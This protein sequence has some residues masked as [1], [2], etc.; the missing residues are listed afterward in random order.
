MAK[1]KVDKEKCIG[2]GLCNEICPET[3]EM[4]GD[5]ATVRKPEVSKVTCEKE[6]EKS[7]PTE[8]ITVE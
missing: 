6:A 5:K 2:C 4:E 8:A 1:I 3:F 7:C